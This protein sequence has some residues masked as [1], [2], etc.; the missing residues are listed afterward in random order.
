MCKALQSTSLF[1]KEIHNDLTKKLL[2]LQYLFLLKKCSLLFSSHCCSVTWNAKD[3]EVGSRGETP[4]GPPAG[5]WLEARGSG[6]P[7][8]MQ[9][10]GCCQQRAA[11]HMPCCRALLCS[12]RDRKLRNS[13]L[14]FWSFCWDS[15]L[16]GLTL[17]WTIQWGVVVEWP[18]LDGSQIGSEPEL[19][20]KN[21]IETTLISLTVLEAA[22]KKRNRRH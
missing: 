21:R 8:T 15:G 4:E 19:S 17:C 3:G 2:S 7:T 16:A 12:S 13:P 14:L 22:F 5:V 6:H 20:N 9:E 11:N 18:G 10:Q 1:L